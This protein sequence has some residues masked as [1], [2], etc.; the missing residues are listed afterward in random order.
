MVTT[1]S[2]TTKK[3]SAAISPEQMQTASPFHMPE[4]PIKQY[5]YFAFRRSLR[6][7]ESYEKAAANMPDDDRR[8]FLAEMTHRKRE[9]AEKLQLYYRADGKWAIQSMKKRSII[10]HPHYAADP[11]FS[12]ISSI[13][14]TYSFAFAREHNNL[15]LYSKLADLDNNPFSKILFHYLSRLQIDHISFI[16]KKMCLTTGFFCAGWKADAPSPR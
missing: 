6:D 3:S 10:S 11:D 13:E 15:N 1:L 5:L 4:K 9:E 2:N 7:S 8:A 14:D 16:E 12:A